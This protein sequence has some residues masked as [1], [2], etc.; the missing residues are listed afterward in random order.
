MKNRKTPRAQRYDYTSQWWYFVTI[1]TKNREHHF[2]EIENGVLQLNELWKYTTEH[3]KYIPDHY[4]HVDVHD[5]ICMP[6][7]IHWII[8]IGDVGTQFLASNIRDTDIRTD[9]NPSL[10]PIWCSSWSLWSIIRGF[11]IWITKYANNNDI[12]FQRQP[13]YH[14]RIIRNND[15]YERIK[16]Y[17]QTNPERW[18]DDVF[19]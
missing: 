15:E 8:I 18:E 3:R 9:K 14:D 16:H 19:Y 4:P 11:K 13:R 12:S 10:Q 7:H 17:I 2:G 1:C 5:F 6:N